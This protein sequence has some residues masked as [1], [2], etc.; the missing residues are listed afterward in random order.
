M[1]IAAA[2]IGQDQQLVGP[3]V[4]LAAMAYP[5]PADRLDRKRRGIGRGA[6]AM[7]PPARPQVVDAVGCGPALGVG[8]EVVDVDLLRV[9]DARRPRDF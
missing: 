6:H 8:D 3:T 2:A 4:S 1:T 5:P 7:W 9:R